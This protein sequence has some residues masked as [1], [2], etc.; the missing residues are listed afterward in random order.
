MKQRILN[1]LK[2][3]N[4]WIALIITIGGLWAGFSEQQATALVGQVFALV[5]AVG[6]F[7]N[8]FK[9]AEFDWKRWI[10]NSNFWNYL[11]VF[12]LAI[13]P[14][15]P[16]EIFGLLEDIVKAIIEKNWNALIGA[17]TTLA[18]FVYKIVTT[19]VNK[20]TEPVPNGRW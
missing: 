5:A 16:P 7:A 15:I 17:I 11:A 13:L 1:A 8:F 14:S 19:K 10:L 3:Q 18:I 9:N 4:F 2:D 20:K 12:I 6:T